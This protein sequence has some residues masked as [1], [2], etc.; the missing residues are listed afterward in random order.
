[1]TVSEFNSFLQKKKLTLAVAESITGGL[2]C[3][4]ITSVS[5]ASE[6]LKCGIVT[7]QPDCKTK[8]L[9]VDSN[10]IT[11][12]S[13]ESAQTTTAMVKG[14]SILEIGASVYIAVTGVA[15]APTT[16][17]KIIK[18]IGQVYASIIYKG[19]LFDFETIINGESRTEIQ[20]KTVAYMMDLVVTVV[21]EH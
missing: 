16:D 3:A 5:G 12:Y 14:L 8:L 13:A 19:Q 9:N 17:Y 4:S 11:K 1:M 6:I 20:Q 7:Y 10:L 2:F 15:S 21:S 18:P